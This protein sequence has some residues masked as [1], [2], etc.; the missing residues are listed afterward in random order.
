MI[1]FQDDF[2]TDYSKML[3]NNVERQ[4]NKYTARIVTIL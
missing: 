1:I 4:I 2:F 3:I